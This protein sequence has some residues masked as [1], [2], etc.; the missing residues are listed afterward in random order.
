MTWSPGTPTTANTVGNVMSQSI[1]AGNAVSINDIVVV[2]ATWDTAS[3]TVTTGVLVDQLGNTYTALLADATTGQALQHFVSLITV[4]GTP[5]CALTFNPIPGSTQANTIGVNLIPFTGSGATT[6]TDGTGAILPQATPTTGT[7]ATTSG[8]WSTSVDGDLI[9]TS[10]LDA[11][12]GA[13][14]G[15]AGT[16]YTLIETSGGGVILKTA[17]RVQS[18]H[19]AST[20]GT[21]T[22]A[23]NDTHVTGA[24]AITPGGGGPTPTPSAVSQSIELGIELGITSGVS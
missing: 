22:A 11:A 19:S 21:W 3:G 5:T 8:T 17:Y 7:D 1:T 12:T 16:G 24:F 20:A 13:N 2:A 15:S 10:T 6:V 9:V 18:T 4:G 14:P 23:A